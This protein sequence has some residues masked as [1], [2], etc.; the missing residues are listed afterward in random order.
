VRSRIPREILAW[1]EIAEGLLPTIEELTVEELN[2]NLRAAGVDPRDLV[3]RY[4]STLG[5]AA[6]VEGRTPIPLIP[7]DEMKA[8]PAG[9]ARLLGDLLASQMFALFR[10]RRGGWNEKPWEGT[11]VF[12]KTLRRARLARMLLEE[13]VF[14][15][16]AGFG[17]IEEAIREVSADH[18]GQLDPFWPVLEALEEAAPEV[19]AEKALAECFASRYAALAV[20]CQVPAL[21]PVLG[22]GINEFL[23]RGLQSARLGSMIAHRLVDADTS[24][25][26]RCILA[27]LRVLRPAMRRRLPNAPP[28]SR[29]GR[30]L[31]SSLF[32]QTH[33]AS[34][35]V[36]GVSPSNRLSY[37]MILNS[38]FQELLRAMTADSPLAA[39]L[40]MG[41]VKLVLRSF[42]GM[43]RSAPEDCRL[44]AV[45]FMCRTVVEQAVPT[46]NPFLAIEAM[47]GIRDKFPEEFGLVM[48]RMLLAASPQLRQGIFIC[49]SEGY[50][51]DFGGRRQEDVP[52][53]KLVGTAIRFMIP[54]AHPLNQ[55]GKRVARLATGD[56]ALRVH[57]DWMN[58]RLQLWQNG[59]AA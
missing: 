6:S 36:A 31:L 21:I 34:T 2:D 57:L 26:I 27:V 12:G 52:Q 13:R 20:R 58:A 43:L 28:E 3:R 30:E 8:A 22:W 14:L 16:N 42:C 47:E 37:P 48:V 38:D 24:D 4:Y 41:C 18:A 44:P 45:D 10:A 49:M 39:V 25:Q 7:A 40:A 15:V 56:V 9:N 17:A 50:E 55:F 5:T 54:S 19:T 33:T 1:Q 23:E 46:N 32:A 53:F 29:A 51:E 59:E 35:L 11:H